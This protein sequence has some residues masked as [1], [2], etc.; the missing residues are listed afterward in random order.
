MRKIDPVFLANGLYVAADVFWYSRPESTDPYK[1]TDD[2]A[3]AAP[4]SAVNVTAAA[5]FIFIPSPELAYPASPWQPEIPMH[6][7]LSVTTT[8]RDFWS[9]D[10]RRSASISASSG[11]NWRHRWT[12][13]RLREARSAHP[14]AKLLL[15]ECLTLW[16]RERDPP[17][18]CA[19]PPQRTLIPRGR[20]HDAR[21]R[22]FNAFMRG[23]VL[24]LDQ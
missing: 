12:I 3:C 19:I 21:A 4:V 17:F 1:V 11:N 9:A 10:H 14:C 16:S 6:R 7:R 2:C 15:E 23:S 20:L 5:N 8:L 22:C 18:A 24:L 13:R